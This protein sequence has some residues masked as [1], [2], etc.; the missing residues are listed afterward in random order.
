MRNLLIL[1]VLLLLSCR[2]TNQSISS[3]TLQVNHQSL[4]RIRDSISTVNYPERENPNDSSISMQLDSVRIITADDYPITNK[5]L[6]EIYR[7]S[8]SLKFKIGKIFSLDK[9]WYSNDSLN[10]SLVFELYTDFHRLYIYN[11]KNDFV[12]DKLIDDISL[13][14]T[15]SRYENVFDEASFDQKKLSINDFIKIS[16]RI[17]SKF[18]T[19]IKGINLGDKKEK[20]ISQYDQPDTACYDNDVEVLKWDYHG[21]YDLIGDTKTIE[22]KALKGKPVVR[23]SFGQHIK[24]F[25]KNNKLIAISI[26]NDI[27]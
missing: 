19:T 2:N 27:P 9:V 7:N 20:L 24:A 15:T 8:E 11:F 10:Q 1:Q 5:M 16:T 12:P 6:D 21:D 13:S 4:D 25:F 14:T 22:V 17:N 26:M 3:D 23:E 18:F